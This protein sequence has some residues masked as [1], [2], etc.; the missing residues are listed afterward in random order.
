MPDWFPVAK[1]IATF[2]L[3]LY[4]AVLS[5]FNW[6]QASRK[7][8]R[9]IR[10]AVSTAMP[11]IGGW[12]GSYIRIEAT[13]AGHRPVTV[14]MLTLEVPSGGRIVKFSPRT[15]PGMDD[16]TLP[17]TLTD[18][19]TAFRYLSY[20]DIGYALIESGRPEKIKLTPVCDDS[21]GAT[22]RGEAFEIDPHEYARN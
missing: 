10:V 8:R 21:V 19:Q 11:Y 18:G 6:R 22:H 13:N 7:D 12:R 4:A 17:V 15:L 14:T 5:T 3:A 20:A 16:T 9:A 1:D 2:V